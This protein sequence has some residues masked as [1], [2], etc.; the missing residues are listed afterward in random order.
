MYSSSGTEI[1]KK[2]DQ[3]DLLLRTR[4]G[5]LGGSRHASGGPFSAT[6]HSNSP[7]EEPAFTPPAT[8][9]AEYGESSEGGCYTSDEDE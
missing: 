9:P 3:I 4:A 7:L 1:Q 6:S 8:P 5:T 2:M